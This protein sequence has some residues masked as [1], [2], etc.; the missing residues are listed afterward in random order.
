MKGTRAAVEVAFVALL[1]MVSVLV[2]RDH[3]QGDSPTFDETYHLLAGAEYVLDG[4]FTANL[5]HPPLMKDLA[6]LS[7]ASSAALPPSRFV[8]RDASPTGRFLPFLYSNRLP[9][10]RMVA[11]GRR[12]FP[13]LLAL[14]VAVTYV[15]ARGL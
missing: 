6:G 9:P 4:T 11:L 1:S 3:Q 7:L 10:D 5:E 13:W 8:P 2:V 12:P 15:A 14:L